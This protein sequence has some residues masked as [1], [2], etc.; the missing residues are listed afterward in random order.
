MEGMSDADIVAAS[1]D[2][3]LLLGEQKLQMDH[4]HK[5]EG[6]AIDD[7]GP[8]THIRL[9]IFP[10]GGISRVRIFGTLAKED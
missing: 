1:E 9:N 3:P 6:A 5:F 4:I 7:V 8:I 10:D 2:W